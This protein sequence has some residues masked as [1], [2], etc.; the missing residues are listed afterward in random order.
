MQL[1]CAGGS[2]SS[3]ATPCGV[4]LVDRFKDCETGRSEVV[5]AIACLL[6][7][8]AMLSCPF[9]AQRPWSRCETPPR[10]LCSAKSSGWSYLEQ[11]PRGNKC[12]I[13][14]MTKAVWNAVS[15][16]GLSDK[17]FRGLSFKLFFSWSSSCVASSERF[18]VVVGWT[19]AGH[20][21]R[22][23]AMSRAS[24]QLA[25]HNGR[26]PITA[27]Q[28][29]S[30]WNIITTWL[31]ILPAWIVRVS[32][33]AQS[34]ASILLINCEQDQASR[35]QNLLQA[36]CLEFTQPFLMRAHAAI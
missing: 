35:K 15:A 9:Q 26:M 25:K 7:I 19:Q 20:E 22:I 23:A 11:M 10:S 1:R 32:L 27:G 28:K 33:S 4:D 2:V 8:R 5:I 31:T 36:K 6:P 29:S 16:Y 30:L 12:I 24:Q 18:D 13:R 21:S 34:F 14:M 3:S 17:D